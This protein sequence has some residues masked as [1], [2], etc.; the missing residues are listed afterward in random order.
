MS[1][2]SHENEDQHN[3][4]NG[5]TNNAFIEG[6]QIVFMSKDVPKYLKGVEEIVSINC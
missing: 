2:H 5:F 6:K 3:L 4:Q 1:V